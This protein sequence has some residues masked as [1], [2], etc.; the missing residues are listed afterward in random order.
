MAI[1]FLSNRQGDNGHLWLTHRRQHRFETINPGVQRLLHHTNHARGPG[2]GGHFGDGI[3]Q[4]LLLEIGDLLLAANQIN[5]GVA[6]VAAVLAGQYIGIH[7]LMS[8]MKRAKT[9][10]N[11]TGD[12]CAAIVGRQRGV[13]G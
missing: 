12:Q 4:I 13:S 5:F 10:M 9:K 8:A 6:P 2:V 7:S 3:Q 11:D 1:A